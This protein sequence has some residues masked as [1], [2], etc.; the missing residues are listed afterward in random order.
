LLI[1]KSCTQDGCRR[2]G[3]W[4]YGAGLPS[5]CHHFDVSVSLQANGELAPLYY[6]TF[7]FVVVF[8]LFNVLLAIIID[9]YQ[10]AAEQSR[11]SVSVS[12]DAAFVLQKLAYHLS[13]FAGKRTISS[14]ELAR[15]VDNMRKQVMRDECLIL[16]LNAHTFSR[17]RFILRCQSYHIHSSCFQMSWPDIQTLNV[18]SEKI[19][20][21]QINWA[22][23]RYWHCIDA[24][25]LYNWSRYLGQR[26]SICILALLRNLFLDVLL[27]LWMA[28]INQWRNDSRNN[29]LRQQQEFLPPVTST[30]PSWE[31]AVYLRPRD[32][33]SKSAQQACGCD[34][35]AFQP[36]EYGGMRAR[37]AWQLQCG[38]LLV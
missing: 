28:I 37:N 7:C 17:E 35:Q 33:A 36:G 15:V 26:T 14:E 5:V 18:A 30:L 24:N 25:E 3:F 34:F 38:R 2:C 19:I 31:I 13:A 10:Q 4:C 23:L 22:F 27:N 1:C 16:L 29:K 20:R 11:E 21:V 12:Q 9:A 6:V 32:V 8:V